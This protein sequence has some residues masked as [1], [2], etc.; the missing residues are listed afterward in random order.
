MFWCRQ[1]GF[2]HFETHMYVHVGRTSEMTFYFLLEGIFLAEGNTIRRNDLSKDSEI[3][4]DTF[5]LKCY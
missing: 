5:W 1:F 3:V 2:R 4:F